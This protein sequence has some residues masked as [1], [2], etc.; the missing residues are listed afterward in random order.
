MS[1]NAGNDEFGNF[2]EILPADLTILAS[3]LGPLSQA[4]S[5]EVWDLVKY[6]QIRHFRHCL[7]FWTYLIGGA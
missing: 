7:H 4:H 3:L 5:S 2:D 6:R 1:R